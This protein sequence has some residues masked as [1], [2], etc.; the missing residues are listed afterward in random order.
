M[1][2]GA[3]ACAVLGHTACWDA[4]FPSTALQCMRD[5]KTERQTAH[6]EHPLVC[7]FVC[8][9]F[10]FSCKMRQNRRDPF[11]N[12]FRKKGKCWRV[13]VMSASS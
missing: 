6:F 12:F 3:A 8:V 4:H 9:C 13:G 5:L 10:F 7:W 11:L 1:G 2:E